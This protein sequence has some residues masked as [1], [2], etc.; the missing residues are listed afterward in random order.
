[1]ARRLHHY[2]LEGSASCFCRQDVVR[3]TAR[4]RPMNTFIPAL[5]LAMFQLLGGE[6]TY[7]VRSGDSLTSI[8]ARYGVDE[9]VLAA[10]NGL[11]ESSRL[12]SGQEL[13]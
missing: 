10:A 12:K 3:G 13:Q 6:W 8:G 9:R 4:G 1:M 2:V 11:E 5:V 7:T